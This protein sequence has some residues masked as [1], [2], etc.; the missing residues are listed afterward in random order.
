MTMPMTAGPVR[1]VV[2]DPTKRTLPTAYVVLT[3]D[4]L[5][6]ESYDATANLLLSYERSIVQLPMFAPD[7]RTALMVIGTVPFGAADGYGDSARRFTR[8]T[9]TEL[10]TTA[11]C[12]GAP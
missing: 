11:D 1:P 10:L 7:A 3:T 9:F 6:L 2:D 12:A 8:A 5:A 4:P